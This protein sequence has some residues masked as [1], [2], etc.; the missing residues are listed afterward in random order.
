[1]VSLVE[2]E[3]EK[4]QKGQ[5]SQGWASVTGDFLTGESPDPPLPS[6]PGKNYIRRIF[7]SFRQASTWVP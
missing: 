5:S 7:G 6:E 1:M 3:A 4:T 2:V